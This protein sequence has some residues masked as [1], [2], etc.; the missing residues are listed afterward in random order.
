MSLFVDRQKCHVASASGQSLAMPQDSAVF[1]RRRHN[2]F[3]RGIDLQRRIDSGI[4]GFSSATGENDLSGFAV[5]ERRD[6]FSRSIDRLPHLRAKFVTARGI[7]VEP[8]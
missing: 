3:T 7:A 5:Q 2:V 1:H 4:V 6:A 8:G